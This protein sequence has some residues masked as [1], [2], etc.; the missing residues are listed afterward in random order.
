MQ[1]RE[2]VVLLAE[3]VAADLVEPPEQ[4]ESWR[5]GVEQGGLRGVMLGTQ[6]AGQRHLAT[7]RQLR[8]EHGLGGSVNAQRSAQA[9][10]QR[11]D[12]LSSP[13]R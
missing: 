9:G 5:A 2:E 7:H 1:R 3:D 4:G 13:D 8:I 10:E 11:V 6:I 12:R